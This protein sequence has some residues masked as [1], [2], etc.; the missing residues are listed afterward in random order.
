MSCSECWPTLVDGSASSFLYIL[1][2]LNQDRVPNL[3]LPVYP[4]CFLQPT[5]SQLP[6]F[7]LLLI[8]SVPLIPCKEVYH[9]LLLLKIK[10]EDI[11]LFADI[12]EGGRS[13]ENP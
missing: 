5:P 3:L 9:P 8:Q 12:S 6:F 10:G 4:F 7:M 2:V 11:S 13:D 1:T